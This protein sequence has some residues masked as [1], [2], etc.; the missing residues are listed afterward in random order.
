MWYE[1]PL[2]CYKS[3]LRA[4]GTEKHSMNSKLQ[5]FQNKTLFSNFV[6][7][8]GVVFL[9]LSC[10]TLQMLEGAIKFSYKNM[11]ITANSMAVQNLSI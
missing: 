5:S 10:T 11:H 6:T 1:L 3:E 4:M 9:S 2:I 8:C 7:L